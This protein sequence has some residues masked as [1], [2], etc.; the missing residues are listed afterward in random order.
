MKKQQKDDY[1]EHGIRPTDP[2]TG[3][4]ELDHCES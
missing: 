1:P 4:G 3:G 2:E